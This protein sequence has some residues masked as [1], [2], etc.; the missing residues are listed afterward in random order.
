MPTKRHE[1][2]G[3]SYRI[4]SAK[5]DATEF[6]TWRLDADG[7]VHVVVNEEHP[8]YSR[9]Y[10]PLCGGRNNSISVALECLLLAAARAEAGLCGKNGHGKYLTRHRQAWSDALAV[11]LGL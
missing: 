3:L 9:L 2:H 7:V 8:F 10:E 1:Y 11:F 4:E 6:F 5:S